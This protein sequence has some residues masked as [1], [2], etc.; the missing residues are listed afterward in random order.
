MNSNRIV[1]YSDELFDE[2]KRTKFPVPNLKH[3]EI[4]IPLHQI[5]D[6]ANKHDV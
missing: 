4:E 3:I 2:K 5:L 6:G 1:V